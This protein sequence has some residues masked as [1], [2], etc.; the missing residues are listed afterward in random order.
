M[1]GSGDKGTGLKVCIYNSLNI[2]YLTDTVKSWWKVRDIKQKYPGLPIY[3]KSESNN[4]ELIQS[5]MN[6]SDHHVLIESG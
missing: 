6:G 1:K 5:N 3:Q 2:N 4:N